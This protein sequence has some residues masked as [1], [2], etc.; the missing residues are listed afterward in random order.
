MV[1]QVEDCADILNTL[2]PEY[3]YLFLVDHSCGH[4]KQRE[5]GLNVEN[6]SKTFG[7]KQSKMHLTTIK[8]EKGYL[9]PYP[10]TLQVGDIQHMMFQPE[11]DGPFWLSTA[12]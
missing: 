11:D 9:G 1:L 10:H 12:Q 2:F 4:D 6:M 3:D 5:D 7:G 8:Q